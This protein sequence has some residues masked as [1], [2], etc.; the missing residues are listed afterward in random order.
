MK[1]SLILGVALM[2]VLTSCK[3]SIKPEK[4][5]FLKMGMSKEEVIEKIGQP[6]VY[7]GSM[8][9]NHNQQIETYEYLVDTGVNEEQMAGYITLSICTL[10]LFAPFY[11]LLKREMDQYWLYFFNNKLVKWCKAGDFETAQHNIQEIR[12]R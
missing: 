8:I 4:L 5:H 9:N 2:L 6:T 7:R 3:R 1:K 12:F 11:P 10:G